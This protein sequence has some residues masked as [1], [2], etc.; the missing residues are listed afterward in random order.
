M[1]CPS[2]DVIRLIQVLIVPKRNICCSI[3]DPKLCRWPL[4]YR[5]GEC[6]YYIYEIFL[7]LKRCYVKNKLF[8][9]PRR[10]DKNQHYWNINYIF[11]FFTIIKK[12]TI[13]YVGT[14]LAGIIGNVIVCLVIIRHSSMHTATNYYL[15]SLAVSDLVYLLFGKSNLQLS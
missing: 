5:Y 13:L 15:F 11:P 12:V 1:S 10:K 8:C 2:I 7:I 14:F 9:L 3:V 4:F 6:F